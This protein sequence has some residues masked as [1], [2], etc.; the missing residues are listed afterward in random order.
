MCLRKKSMFSKQSPEKFKSGTVNAW[1]S[2][3]PFFFVKRNKMMKRQPTVIAVLILRCKIDTVLQQHWAYSGQVL[4][5]SQMQRR[6]SVFG[7]LIY[8]GSSK[9]LESG[10]KL[11]I[12]MICTAMSVLTNTNA[13]VWKR[14]EVYQIADDDLRAGLH[15]QVERGEFGS[16]LNP[17]V[18]ISLDADQK[19]D[20]FDVRVLNG[21][22]QEIP[23]F[24]VHLKRSRR[25][26]ITKWL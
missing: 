8:F 7:H 5:G 13:Q 19:Q 17:G 25:V 22:M 14:I 10:K 2:Q 6:L 23:A 1:F 4:L 20:A 11:L 16:I 26:Q 9:Q 21:H 3:H 24:V 12:S 15:S 18:D